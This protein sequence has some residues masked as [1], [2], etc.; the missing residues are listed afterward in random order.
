MKI[1]VKPTATLV[2]TLALI[3]SFVAF[4]P[5]AL[6]DSAS[7]TWTTVEAPL[8]PVSGAATVSL[9][10]LSCP[11]STFCV[12]VGSVKGSTSGTQPLVEE[13]TAGAWNTASASV[14]VPSNSASGSSQ[15]ASLSAVSCSS[16][17]FCVAVGTYVD[18]SNGQSG[19]LDTLSGGSWTSVEA[20]EPSDGGTDADNLQLSSLDAVTCSADG[21]CVA[22]GFYTSSVAGVPQYGLI[23]TLSGGTWTA[24]SVPENGA[25]INAIS[26][27]S[28]STT[29]VAVGGWFNSSSNFGEALIDTYSGGT[30]SV[31][32]E[33]PVPSNAVAYSYTLSNLSSVACPSSTSCVSVGQYGASNS[34]AGLIE[35][36]AS[37]SWAATPAPLPSN[38]GSSANANLVSVGCPTD[39]SCVAVGTYDETLGATE[40]LI[41]TLGNGSWAANGAPTPSASDSSANLQSA[42]CESASVCAVVGKFEDSSGN[43]S[44]LADFLLGGVW[45]GAQAPVPTNAASP[46]TAALNAMACPSAASCVAV[47]TYTDSSGNSLGMLDSY[48]F[49]P[50]VPPTTSTTTQ[51]ETN[52]IP[53][54]I[55]GLTPS[56]G[57]ASSKLVLKG[58]GFTRSSAVYFGNRPAPRV[59]Y[60]SQ[61][62]LVAT[63]PP[64]HG[65]VPITVRNAGSSTVPGSIRFT[66]AYLPGIATVVAGSGTVDPGAAAVTFWCERASCHFL[67]RLTVGSRVV[68]DP[69]HVNIRR[70]H[71]AR[72]RLFPASRKTFARTDVQA[73][74]RTGVVKI[75][76]EES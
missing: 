11:S 21:S 28:D 2:G 35:T 76:T 18:T 6:A 48:A 46:S 12:A 62:E 50:P 26:C 36:F 73:I 16:A 42:E 57:F 54:R 52:T 41:D 68:A 37:G 14:P 56:E 51:T 5:I 60:G 29:C 27:S 58:S 66:F 71:K 17:S 67:A 44:P 10:S 70:G 55:S 30:W 38:A 22:G 33:P 39:G 31:I 65:R 4:A 43:V 72:I 3:A 64:G 13:W 7:G 59:L 53:P 69:Q 25:Q 1:R 40:G 75:R 47:G 49:S 23:N 8:P 19:F 34:Y 24:T 74:R 61:S 15:D 45:N 63:I 20:P 32:S 9:A